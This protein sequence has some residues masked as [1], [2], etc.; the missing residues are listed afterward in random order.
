MS[1][2]II[3]TSIGSDF[4][5]LGTLEDSTSE[6]VRS[7]TIRKA[8]LQDNCSGFRFGVSAGVSIGRVQTEAGAAER[9]VLQV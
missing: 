3:W 7:T 8:R 4:R 1:F 9:A 5:T 2:V 6:R